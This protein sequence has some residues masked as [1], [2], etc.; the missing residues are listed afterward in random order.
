MHTWHSSFTII[1]GI[2]GHP[3]STWT[4]FCAFQTP[5]SSARTLTCYSQFDFLVI[6][7]YIYGCGLQGGHRNLYMGKYIARNLINLDI[8]HKGCRAHCVGGMSAATITAR[9]IETFVHA[10]LTKYNAKIAFYH[11]EKTSS[12]CFFYKKK[13]NYIYFIIQTCF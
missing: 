7:T 9:L 1:H 11:K 3:Y 10:N 4:L 6:P 8:S 13:A 2:R 12:L 5:T